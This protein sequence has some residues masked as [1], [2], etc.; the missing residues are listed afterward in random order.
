MVKPVSKALIEPARSRKDTPLPAHAF[1]VFTQ[2]DMG[3]MRAQW[4]E[5]QPR[6]RLFLSDVVVAEDHAAGV[7]LVGPMIGA[8]QAVMVLEK[9]IVLGVRRVV[10][11]GWCGSLQPHVSV[12]DVVLPT[13]AYSEEGTSS[14]YPLSTPAT[15]SPALLQQL[16]TLLQ[17]DKAFR[18]HKGSVWSTDAPYRETK[19][20]VFLYQQKGALGV[21]MEMSALLTVA[22]FRGIDLAGVLVV[23]DDLSRLR[24]RH[25]FRDP[26]FQETRK[27]VPALLRHLF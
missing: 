10:A 14:H 13:S 5:T 20:K 19:E 15:P 18:V 7:V 9:I 11:L 24:W 2:Q 23:S 17:K 26:R 1:L 21:D 25:G 27:R 16:Q 22:A 8:P 6:P 12:G 3:L 4:P